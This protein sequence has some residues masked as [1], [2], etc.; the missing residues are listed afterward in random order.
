MK[1]ICTLFEKDPDDLG[2]VVDL[3]PY[4]NEWVLTHGIATRKYD[5]T[6][7]AII[8]GEL[9]K[10]YDVKKDRVVPDG[11]IPCQEADTITG[12]HPH[13]I[14]VIV[15]DKY[16]LEG[17]ANSASNL[18]EGT[19]ELVGPKVQ[20]NAENF[21]NHMLIQHGLHILTDVPNYTFEGIKQYLIDHVMEGIVFYHSDLGDTRMCKIRRKDFGLKWPV[22]IG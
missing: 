6:A 11:A 2:R 14:K 4:K 13:W 8:N 3:I 12:H 10:R 17:L 21:P 1:K 19:Y 20:S 9:Y 16:H 7:C 18:P 22:L 5:G 15:S